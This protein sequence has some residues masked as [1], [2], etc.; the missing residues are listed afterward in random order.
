MPTTYP[1][2]SPTEVLGLVVLL[3]DHK[4]S[5]DV[6]LLADDLDLEIDEILPATEF[7]EAL[8]LIQLSNGRASLT[9][10]GKR[11]LEASIRDRK[12]V[13]REQLKKTTLFRTL[14]KALENKP[15]RRL[16]EDEL[17][18]LVEFTTAPSDDFV[19]NII[20]WGRFTELFRYDAEQ[21][22][23]LLG[24]YRTAAHPTASG[25][26]RPPDS[27]VDGSPSKGSRAATTSPPAAPS[28]TPKVAPA[29]SST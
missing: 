26:S 24:K 29:L 4:G 5:Q 7:A 14:L 10:V 20:N 18:A 13:L 2:A 25:G 11:L 19:Q 17:N 9:E 22:V 3:K 23:L 28:G 1:R 6:A 8:Q 21:R 16:S 15:D 12:L 27:S